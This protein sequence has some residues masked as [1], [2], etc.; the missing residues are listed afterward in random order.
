[1]KTKTKLFDN[2]YNGKSI[3][4]TGHTGFQGSW[5]SIWLRM[6][7]A[8][9]IGYGLEPY[10]KN[11]NYVVSDLENKMMNIIGDLRDYDLLKETI[12]DHLSPYRGQ[13]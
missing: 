13:S 11:D 1:M 12:K 2:F 5:L 3:L 6:L 10:T 9:V 7:G 8:K 4:I